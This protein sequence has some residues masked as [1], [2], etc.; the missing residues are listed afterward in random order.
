MSTFITSP[1]MLSQQNPTSPC[2]TGDIDCAQLRERIG[3]RLTLSGGAHVERILHDLVR[4][5]AKVVLACV[6]AANLKSLVLAGSCGRG[7][8]GIRVEHWVRLRSAAAK[9]LWLDMWSKAF[10]KHYVASLKRLGIGVDAMAR[11]AA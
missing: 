10:R 3:G 1:A 4:K 9:L 2:G 6:P 7:E 5:A 8:G 11:A